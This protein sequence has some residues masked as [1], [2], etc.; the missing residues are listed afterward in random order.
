MVT[1]LKRIGKAPTTEPLFR[2]D[3]EDKYGNLK[4]PAVEGKPMK[5]SFGSAFKEARKAGLMSFTWNG[6]KYTTRQAGEDAAKHKAAI[7][8]IKQKN[9]SAFDDKIK[10]LSKKK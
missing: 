2:Q 1:R 9:S 10:E 7:A 8:K 3:G 4:K 6:K 5:K